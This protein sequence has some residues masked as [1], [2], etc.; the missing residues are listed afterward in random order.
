M[1]EDFG[2]CAGAFCYRSYRRQ[3]DPC[4]GCP[5]MKTFEDGQSHYSESVFISRSMEQFDV[6]TWTTPIRDPSGEITHVMS[7]SNDVTKVRKLQSHL[8]SL[9]LLVGTISHQV[10]GMLTGL[11]GG[12]YMVNSG[13]AK[14]N[15]Q[16]VKEG[17]Q[18]VTLVVSRL[19][20]MILDILYYAR[21]RELEWERTPVLPFAEEAASMIEPKLAPQN[22]EFI[23]EFD[24]E[25]GTLELDTGMITSALMNIFQNAIDA[26]VEDG[27]KPVHRISFEVDGDRDT[28]TF[29]IRDDGAGMDS[30]TREKLFTMFFSSKGQ[31]GTGL[32][33]FVSNQVIRQHGGNIRVESEPGRG[34]CFTI[35]LPRY[36]KFS[37]PEKEDSDS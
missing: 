37:S 36:R 34:S 14:G 4:P 27:S 5:V 21:E 16:Q 28:V 20:K 26:C 7:M 29:R 8:S 15:H 24:P 1:K 9:G 6:L 10:K 17:W 18:T 2:D 30:A 13:I 32:G 33:L 31:K 23:R 22:I 19:R 12:V 25:A 3:E 35:T 11:D